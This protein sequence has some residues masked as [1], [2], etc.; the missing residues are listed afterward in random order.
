M[1]PQQ[2]A[3]LAYDNFTVLDLTGPFEVLSKLPNYKSIII[4]EKPGLITGGGGMQIKADFSIEEIPNP[5]ILLIPGGFGIDNL[6]ENKNIISWI[7]K[8]HKTSKW[9][10]SVC[11][12]ALLLGAAGL[13]KDKQA[14]T[15]WN[16]REQLKKYGVSV[17]NERYCKDGKIICSAGV[18]AGIDMALYLLSLEVNEMFAK[19]IQ[20]G[21]EYDPKPPFD[22]GS[23]E[24]APKQLVE[25]V[26]KRSK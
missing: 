18:S 17:V 9:T 19:A 5:E 23:P 20:L 1:E 2:I 3:Y 4:A 21:M 15:H 14:T 10:L 22:C 16:R 6:L 11:S 26:M 25:A 8:A 13:L 7:Q 24:K 12:G